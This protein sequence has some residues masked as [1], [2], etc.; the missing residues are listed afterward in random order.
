ME[1]MKQVLGLDLEGAKALIESEGLTVGNVAE[2]YSADA[3]V[4]TVIAQSVAAGAQVLR[5]DEAGSITLWLRSGGYRV[6]TYLR[7]SGS[8]AYA[9]SRPHILSRVGR[10]GR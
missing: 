3:P 7:P 10:A 4:R 9:D 1:P 2:G 8:C 6:E 5:T